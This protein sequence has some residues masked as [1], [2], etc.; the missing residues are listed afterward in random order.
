M[1]DKL[2]QPPYPLPDGIKSVAN[3]LRDRKNIVVLAGAGLSVSC[4]IPDFRSRDTGLYS[5]L[6]ATALGLSTPEDL[7]DYETFVENP[8]P[9]YKFAKFLYPGTVEPS[10]SHYF[11]SLLEQN[12]VLRRVYT[13]NI[14][15]LEELAGVTGEKLVYAHGSLTVAK[16]LTC[17]AKLNSRDILS[18]VMKGKIPRCA[19]VVP[20]VIPKKARKKGKSS[21]SS[22]QTRNE[23]MFDKNA[24]DSTIDS[25]F[26]SSKKS[27]SSLNSTPALLMSTRP[28]R[29]R[30]ANT[31]LSEYVQLDGGINN[32]TKYESKE[33]N[34]YTRDPDEDQYCSGI[35]KPGV[36]FFGEMLDDEVGKALEY[37][38]DKI[39][40][41][42]VIGTSLSVAPMSKVI[43]YLSSSIPRILINRNYVSPPKTSST[44]DNDDDEKLRDG[45]SYIFDACMLGNCDEITRS[46]VQEMDWLEKEKSGKKEKCDNIAIS[47]DC[48][49][50]RKDDKISKQSNST[51]KIKKIPEV[52]PTSSCARMEGN[53][54]LDRTFIFKGAVLDNDEEVLINETVHC[55]GCTAEISGVVMRC[56]TCFDYD[57]CKKCYK[58]EKKEKNHFSGLHDFIAEK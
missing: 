22:R 38:Y 51:S 33:A 43:G 37:D 15:G 36:T 28:V 8:S 20:K 42:I 45:G 25:D 46:L 56:S 10:Y 57:L 39:D 53:P 16:C 29:K 13:Q 40:A 31:N 24:P 21:A 35:I 9:F 1:T 27:I 49:L 50:L 14:D 26:I 17:H 58:K 47:N 4:G 2:P 18:D 5:T 44:C 32:E 7:F 19:K 23:Y 48:S 3:L 11:L 54:I 52:I 6:D 12:G 30:R 41:L 55:D 34:T